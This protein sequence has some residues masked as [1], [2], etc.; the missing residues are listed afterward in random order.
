MPVAARRHRRQLVVT[1]SAAFGRYG[2]SPLLR[3][4][5]KTMSYNFRHPPASIRHRRRILAPEH[6]G[7]NHRPLTVRGPRIRLPPRPSR[8]APT[9]CARLWSITSHHNWLSQTL[10]PVAQQR[11]GLGA[12]STCRGRRAT[13]PPAPPPTSRGWNAFVVSAIATS[14]RRV[15]CAPSGAHILNAGSH[16]IPRIVGVGTPCLVGGIAGVGQ[17]VAVDRW[18]I[19]WSSV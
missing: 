12:G 6:S 15:A 14:C 5:V 8:T 18:R 3:D 9:D 2:G 11:C 4:G 17:S 10:L 1:G 16:R 7:C 13:G 19:Y